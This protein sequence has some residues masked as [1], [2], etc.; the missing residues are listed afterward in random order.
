[1]LNF[2]SATTAWQRQTKREAKACM[3]CGKPFMRS[4]SKAGNIAKGDFL[5]P[6]HAP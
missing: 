4:V 5:G 6:I 1:M 2:H 3:A